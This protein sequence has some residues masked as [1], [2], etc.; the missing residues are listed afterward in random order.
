MK[1]GKMKKNVKMLILTSEQCVEHL[2]PGQNTQQSC[3]SNIKKSPW[4]GGQ[5]AVS[6]T[7]SRIWSH[8]L[9]T[10]ALMF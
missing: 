8:L 9:K 6:S 5:N 3:H 10:I 1:R 2:F 4:V 7:S